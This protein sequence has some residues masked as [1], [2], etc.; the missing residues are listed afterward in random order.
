M[1]LSNKGNTKH[2]KKDIS[3]FSQNAD[4]ILRQL[5]DIM[6]VRQDIDDGYMEL[7]AYSVL[8]GIFLVLND[9]HAT[10]IPLTPSMLM[11]DV[12][13]INYCLDGRCEF[14]LE[15]DSYSYV[16]KNLTSIGSQTVQDYFYY[17]SAYYLGYEFYILPS[18]FTD[19]TSHVL[20]LFSIDFSVLAARYQKN[21]PCVTPDSLVQLWN[22]MQHVQKQG[23]IGFIRLTAMQ[24]LHYLCHENV[25]P[26]CANLFLTKTQSNLAKKAKAILTEDLSRHIAIRTIAES[27]GV[28]ET[29][30]KN[31]FRSVYGM[32][33]SQY[34]N[35]ERMQLAARLLTET[36]M[37]GSDIAKAC[38]YV[39]QGRFAKIFRDFYGMKPLD[40]RRNSRLTNQTTGSPI[41]QKPRKIL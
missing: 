27:F 6:T 29:S 28:S 23:D 26:S 41:L 4:K 8:P 21:V 25:L 17:P 31:Y 1:V 38:G 16:S 32:T 14:R 36:T 5:Q 40:Y 22:A 39:N 33:I 7:T 34:L 13:T 15:D 37:N 2:M 18:L 11:T 19:E 3:T 9:V 20:R 10:V 35:E 24:I 12:F 30:L